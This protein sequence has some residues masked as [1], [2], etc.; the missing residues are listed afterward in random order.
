MSGCMEDTSLRIASFSSN[1]MKGRFKYPHNQKSD[2]VKSGKEA[3]YC[4]VLSSPNV[5]IRELWVCDWSHMNVYIRN[6]TAEIFTLSIHLLGTSILYIWCI[7]NGFCVCTQRGHP[8]NATVMK[9]FRFQLHGLLSSMVVQLV[10][11]PPTF[12]GKQEGVKG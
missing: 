5:C 3:M 12:Q 10:L 8:T 6:Y 1:R 4:F 11:N 9:L 2:S 7:F